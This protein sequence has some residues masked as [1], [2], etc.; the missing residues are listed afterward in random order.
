MSA[1]E[2]RSISA[3]YLFRIVR[4]PVLPHLLLVDASRRYLAPGIVRC[5]S[6]FPPFIYSSAFSPF[7]PLSRSFI[8]ARAKGARVPRFRVR[9][10]RDARDGRL[11]TLPLMV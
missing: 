3:Q 2:F 10:A 7:R 8:T 1:T 4:L 11:L 5:D 9:D 6:T